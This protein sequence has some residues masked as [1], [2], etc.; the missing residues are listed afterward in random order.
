M[1]VIRKISILLI[2]ASLALNAVSCKKDVD[3]GKVLATV[4]GDTITEKEY[5][6]FKARLRRNLHLDKAKEKKLILEQMATQ[7]LLMQ[8]ALDN[9]I[10]E[11]LDVYL[12]LKR[13]REGLLIGAAQRAILKEY[14]PITDEQI[15]ERFKEEVAA[16]HKIR[17]KASHILLASEADAKAVIAELNKGKDFAALAKSRSKGPTKA[18]GGDLGWVQQGMVVPEFFKA[19]IKLK[20]GSYTKTPVKTQ[21]GWHVIKVT[22]TAKVKIPPFKK[23]KADVARLIQ[24]DRLS[25]KVEALKKKAKIDIK[26][27]S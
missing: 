5:E 18:K 19:L 11:E 23:V 24:Q 1:S 22:D 21:F 13:Q 2:A 3:T 26:A 17:Y 4:N 8:Y 12:A 16:T 14:P 15:K 20:P 10:D 27:E 7:K 9:K 6:F 25:E